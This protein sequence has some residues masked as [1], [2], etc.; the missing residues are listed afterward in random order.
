MVSPASDVLMTQV[1]YV[2]KHGVVHRRY[3]NPTTG[4]GIYFLGDDTGRVYTKNHNLEVT[5]LTCVLLGET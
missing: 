2:D 4:C 3:F 5:C 1:L